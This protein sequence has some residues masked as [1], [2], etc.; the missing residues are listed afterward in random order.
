MKEEFEKVEKPITPFSAYTSTVMQKVL[1]PEEKKIVKYI[2]LIKELIKS[3]EKE[4]TRGVTSHGALFRGAYLDCLQITNS[5]KIGTKYQN[6]IELAVHSNTTLWDLRKLIGGHCSRAYFN[7]ADPA[8]YFQETPC[9]P[10]SIRV[11]RSVGSTD[12]RENENGKTL[13]ELRFKPNEVLTA[14]KKTT[15]NTLAVPL[16]NF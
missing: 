11:F 15:Y 9:H 12:L 6:R 4:G 16:V 7:K 8:S 14:N 2:H 5:L 10:S 3:S 13:A 1:P